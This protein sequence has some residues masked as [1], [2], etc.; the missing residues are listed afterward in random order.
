MVVEGAEVLNE[1]LVPV[2]VLVVVVNALFPKP[3]EQNTPTSLR[4][5]LKMVMENPSQLTVMLPPPLPMNGQT[6]QE[7]TSLIH[8]KPTRQ[9]LLLLL[10]QMERVHGP[11]CL[12]N[13]LQRLH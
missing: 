1:V 8:W 4:N 3:M 11:H 6:S 5:L 12:P 9:S 10:H 2:P 7:R 13:H